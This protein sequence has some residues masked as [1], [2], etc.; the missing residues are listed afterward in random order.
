MWVLAI[1]DC[2][3]F[4]TVLLCAVER[5]A[6]AKVVLR[7]SAAPTSASAHRAL[8]TPAYQSKPTRNPRFSTGSREFVIGRHTHLRQ[9]LISFAYRSQYG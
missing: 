5:Y 3:A 6:I 4:A 1:C 2:N 8:L 7:I 9:Q